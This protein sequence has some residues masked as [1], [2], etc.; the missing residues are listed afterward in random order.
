MAQKAAQ[1]FVLISFNLIFPLDSELLK[2]NYKLVQLIINKNKIG[3][4]HNSKTCV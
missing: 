4:Y 3:S 2:Y 1:D